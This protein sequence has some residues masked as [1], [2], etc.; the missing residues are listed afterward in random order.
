[1]KFAG[2]Y[3]VTSRAP[4]V[5]ARVVLELG[6]S[7]DVVVERARVLIDRSPD[8]CAD[9]AGDQSIVAIEST[10]PSHLVDAIA[11]RVQT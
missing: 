7:L 10:M 11:D 5:W 6:L 2:S 3:L 1:M 8:V 4:D 9:A